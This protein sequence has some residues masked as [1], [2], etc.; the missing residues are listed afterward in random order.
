M[1][2]K[3]KWKERF[4]GG[5][6]E[7]E[8]KHLF[9]ILGNPIFQLDAGKEDHY[10]FEG[11]KLGGLNDYWT[12]NGNKLTSVPHELMLKLLLGLA[13]LQTEKEQ[14]H[15]QEFWETNKPEDMAKRISALKRMLR[16]ISLGALSR[17]LKL[18]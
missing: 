8:Y 7:E 14:E 12:A 3:E 18:I 2:F 10:D 17:K 15:R 16:K 9:D 4:S 5:F 13:K 1:G 6:T 11:S